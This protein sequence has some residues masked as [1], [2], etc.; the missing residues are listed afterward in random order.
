MP[1][2][3]RHHESLISTSLDEITMCGFRA[4]VHYPFA[5]FFRLPKAS[6]PG[7]NLLAI[8]IDATHNNTKQY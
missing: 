6:T 7:K 8:S 3:K 5:P 2:D 4:A 1:F